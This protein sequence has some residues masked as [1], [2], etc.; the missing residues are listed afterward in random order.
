MA[1]ARTSAKI[2]W[3]ATPGEVNGARAESIWIMGL[4]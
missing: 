1:S 4:I 3:K 2:A